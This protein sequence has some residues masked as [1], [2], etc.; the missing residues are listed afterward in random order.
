M[1]RS[2]Q[3]Q[4]KHYLATGEQDALPVGWPGDWIAAATLAN[5]A[6]R[7]ALIEEVKRRADGLSVPTVPVMELTTFTR[8]KV[9]PMVNG[10][11]PRRSAQRFLPCW[12]SL[13]CF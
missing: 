8:G 1:A 5:N 9:A 10:L 6:M 12:K 2:Q 11:F 13:W 7:D 3:Q 4:I